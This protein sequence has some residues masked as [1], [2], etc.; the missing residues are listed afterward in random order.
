MRPPWHQRSSQT[1]STNCHVDFV[2]K[3]LDRANTFACAHKSYCSCTQLTCFGCGLLILHYLQTN[4]ELL[5][6]SKLLM[7]FNQCQKMQHCRYVITT[8]RYVTLDIN[9][10]NQSNTNHFNTYKHDVDDE[11]VIDD[12]TDAV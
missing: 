6:C 4:V 8:N 10:V 1:P 11:N 9:D 5:K 2:K 12:K 3:V 7:N